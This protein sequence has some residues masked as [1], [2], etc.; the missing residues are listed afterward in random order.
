M[1]DPDAL[2]NVIIQE[3]FHTIQTILTSSKTELRINETFFYPLTSPPPRYMEL[4]KPH[5]YTLL[6][7]QQP[8]NFFRTLP[9]AELQ[10][11][12]KQ[13]SI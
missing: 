6:F 3:V 7:F 1:V 12:I 11:P 8:T 5:R 9:A 2:K 10:Q 13:V 4:V